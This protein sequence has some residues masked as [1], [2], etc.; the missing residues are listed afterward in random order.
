MSETDLRAIRNYRRVTNRLATAGQPEAGQFGLIA[1]HFDCI[2]NMDQ[3]DSPYALADEATLAAQ[4]SLDYV[5][6]PVDF[7]HPQMRDFDT[8]C[9]ILQAQ[10]QNR[11]FI[12]CAMNWRVSSF[13]FLYRVGF[14][15]IDMALT[16]CDPQT[17][18]Q[19]DAAWS[20]FI[21]QA[22]QTLSKRERD[23]RSTK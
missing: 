23:H 21:E 4:H 13:V 11:L 10:D 12:H 14:Q 9:E 7:K 18:W 17:V 6:I 8:F 2:S 15:H 19:P 20:T 1:T 5:N 16:H 22:L 3:A